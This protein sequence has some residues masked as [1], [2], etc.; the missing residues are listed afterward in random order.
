MKIKHTLG[1][2]ERTKLHTAWQLIW[3][4]TD[5]HSAFCSCDWCNARALLTH[6][7]EC[8]FSEWADIDEPGKMEV[9]H[10]N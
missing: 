3:D 8:D 2:E 1:D 9:P 10:V 6:D 7:N 4:I 5:S